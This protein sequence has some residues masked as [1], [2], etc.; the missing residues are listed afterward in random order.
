MADPAPVSDLA[1]AF[2][3]PS[4]G[5]SAIN[6]NGQF[7]PQLYLQNHPELTQQYSSDPNADYTYR[8]TIYNLALADALKNG[9]EEEQNAV[10]SGNLAVPSGVV[11]ESGV[12]FDAGEAP[13]LA[14]L[15]HQYATPETAKIDVG[16]NPAIKY[17]ATGS[18]A[19]LEEQILSTVYPGIKSQIAADTSTYGPL[20]DSLQKQSQENFGTLAGVFKNAIPDAS[21]VSPLL[22]QENTAAQT[23]ET[24]QQSALADEMA[25]LYANQAPL[26]QANLDAAESLA[27]A[28]NLAGQQQKQAIDAQ[29]AGQGFVGG[30][31]MEDNALAQALIQAQQQAANA[32]GQAKVQNATANTNIGNYGAGTG[33]NL[34][35]ALAQQEQQNLMNQQPQAT[36]AATGLAGIPATE[37]STIPGIA[38]VANTG[39]LNAQNAL[40][41][42][43][44]PASPSTPGYVPTTPSNYGNELSGLGS[45]L[46][47]GALSVGN[48]N[49][50]WQT[51][52]KTTNPPSASVTNWSPNSPY[53]NPSSLSSAF[54]M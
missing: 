38:N 9:T 54:Q 1:S 19:P 15:G 20:A 45:G 22:T 23:A 42:W 43:S 35:T 50:W 28:A 10:A 39:L 12:G 31:T 27:T 36:A 37:A 11:F 25:K 2:T 6:S 21:G 32:V 18:N 13:A 33:Y 16:N 3:P 47:S 4:G 46:L 17:S 14:G 8:Q 5:G 49:N 29:Y 40:N 24:S 44:S 7:D 41:W 48:A 26:S 34:A 52:S 30:S 51:P 53:S